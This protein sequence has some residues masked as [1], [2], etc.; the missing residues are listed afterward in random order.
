MSFRSKQKLVRANA[1]TYLIKPL[2]G[3]LSVGLALLVGITSTAVQAEN[4]NGVVQFTKP[5]YVVKEDAGK[6]ELCIERRTSSDASKMGAAQVKYASASGSAKAGTDYTAIDGS[7]FWDAGDV[8][9][10]P[11]TVEIKVDTAKEMEESFFVNLLDSVGNSS[12]TA[13]PDMGPLS[14]AEVVIVAAENTAPLPASDPCPMPEPT[15][16][17]TG[18]PGTG[19]PG[20]GTP[21]TGT[22][23]TGTPGTDTPGT[24]TPGT[25]TPGTGT[26]GTGTPGTGTPGTGTTVTQ[27]TQVVQIFKKETTVIQDGD[28]IVVKVF[29]FIKIKIKT[30]TFGNIQ[31][32][33]DPRIPPKPPESPEPRSGEVPTLDASSM[34]FLEALWQSLQAGG[35]G[36]DILIG[37]DGS[38]LVAGTTAGGE[39]YWFSVQAGEPTPYSGNQAAGLYLDGTPYVVF[40]DTD[41]QMKQSILYPTMA[42][43]ILE[44]IATAYPQASLAIAPNGTVT[45]TLAGNTSQ[46][47]A[48]YVV[49]T[50]SD[51]LEVTPAAAGITVSAGGQSQTLSLVK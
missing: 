41:G 24:G 1:P 47:Q 7:V 51:T 12:T 31:I 30:T 48:G 20:T 50:G 11:V 38:I 33:D 34:A 14:R 5:K 28:S 42:P 9:G 4:P 27:F 46:W 18:T 45:F 22:P 8:K 39:S 15:T 43:S 13:A 32:V 35:Y 25:G 40:E 2:Q 44:A 21:G 23:G 49:T 36:D 19:T 10:K 3:T 17:G 26:P 6:V 29:S 37:T 16:P